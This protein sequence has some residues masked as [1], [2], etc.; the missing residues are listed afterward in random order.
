MELKTSVK[1]HNRHDIV[2][3]D[4]TTK[5]E[6]SRGQAENIILNRMYT[7]LSNLNAF[8]TRI[9]FGKGSGVLSATRT[10]LFNQ[11]GSKTATEEE[12]IRE[13]NYAK[14]T[15]RIRLEAHEFNDNTLTEV[16]IADASASVNTHAMITD[17][18]GEPLTI[19]KTSSVIIDIYSTIFVQLYD[20]DS[21]FFFYGNG[22][23]NYLSGGVINTVSH[24]LAVSKSAAEDGATLSTRPTFD[25]VA[26]T[27]SVEGKFG[28]DAFN[29]DIKY[30][31]WQ[32]AGIGCRL[33]RPGVWSGIQR[34]GILIAT[35]DG[36][37][38]EFEIP[39]EDISNLKIY[40]DGVLSSTAA[41]DA[42]RT[43]ITLPAPLAVGSELTID[44]F[45]NLI[46]KAED[47]E[48]T[49]SM[50]L[51]FGA[52]IP[53]PV[54][55]EPDYTE[56]IGP[57][58]LEGGDH[59]RG[60]YGEVTAQELISGDALAAMLG[61]TAG[62]ARNSEEGWLKFAHRGNRLFIAKKTFRGAISWNNIDAVGAAFGKKVRIGNAIYLCRLMST[63]EWND[64]IYPIH[65]E[66]DEWA[67]YTDADIQIGVYTWTSSPSGTSRV[68]RGNNSVTYSTSDTPGT[69]YSSCSWRPVLEFLRN[70]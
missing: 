62:N 6:I 49:I 68:L 47:N 7:R 53:A 55:A 16:G 28:V 17:A 22:L 69:S 63:T 40:V 24:T 31:W 59:W 3:R 39:H 36:V 35:G 43:T 13:H 4:A 33:P 51:E 52:G 67:D 60:F 65:E 54:V 1:L 30:I 56:V 19:E 5:E 21:G 46:P 42:A 48:L 9:N 41:V 25:S 12:V 34:D 2:V 23:R 45:S 26:R 57:A 32:T 15:Q 29:Q 66:F 18:E 14:W 27:V 20:V 61:L 44:C 58:V 11:V 37:Q 10:T 38:S 8:F 70:L 50:T 64:L